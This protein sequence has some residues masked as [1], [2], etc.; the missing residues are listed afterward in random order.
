MFHYSYQRYLDNYIAKV[1]GLEGTRRAL[2]SGKEQIMVFGI[3]RVMPSSVSAWS[4]IKTTISPC[5]IGA[6]TTKPTRFLRQARG[7]LTASARMLEQYPERVAIEKYYNLR[8]NRHRYQPGEG[9]RLARSG[10]SNCSNIR[11]GSNRCGRLRRAEKKRVQ[12]MTK[13]LLNLKEVPKPDDAADA[14]ALAICHAHSSGS[15]MQR[16]QML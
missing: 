4:T 11:L 6:V 7:D 12:E 13:L 14:L 2:S 16:R 8:E 10:A 1:F 15:L 9:V 3:D 5:S